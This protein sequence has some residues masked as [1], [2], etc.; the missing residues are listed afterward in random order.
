MNNERKKRMSDTQPAG[1]FA[2]E[3]SG[4]L[5][6]H[7]W[8][9]LNDTIRAACDRLAAQGFAAFAPDLYGGSVTDQIA[10]AATLAAALDERAD[11]ARAVVLAAAAFLQA[12]TRTPQAGLAVMGFSLGAAYALD[13]SARAPERV[14]SV[15]TFYGTGGADFGRA[16]AEYLCHYAEQDEYEPPD[17]AA[18]LKDTL[19]AAG[20]PA[21]FHHYP[22]TG[23]WFMEPD[24]TQASHAT[25]AALAW[26]RTLAFLRRPVSTKGTPS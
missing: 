11:H 16:K 2:G 23:H 25:A 5:V 17:N 8:W 9:G 6:L 3:G 19:H 10:E 24:R 21:T 18:W 7:A 22:G 14:H 15:V 13:L 1:Y 26:E 20:R 4:V 12:R